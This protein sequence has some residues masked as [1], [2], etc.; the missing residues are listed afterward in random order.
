MRR[1]LSDSDVTD[2]AE[3]DVHFHDIIYMAAD[4]QRL[5]P[6]LNNLREQMY[7]FRVEYLK[8]NQFH[9]RLVKEHGEIIEALASRN[10]ELAVKRTIEHIDNQELVVVHTLTSEE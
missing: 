1:S 10:K 3:A 2:I 7:R 6:I 8:N 5:I 9:P 4:N